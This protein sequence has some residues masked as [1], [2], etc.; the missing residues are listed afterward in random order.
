MNKTIEKY[1]EINN[2]LEQ[3]KSS[4]DVI[5]DQN[6]QFVFIHQMFIIYLFGD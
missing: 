5:I 2:Q 1:Q 4:I 3:F 6:N